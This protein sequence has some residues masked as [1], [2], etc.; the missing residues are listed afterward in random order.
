MG[1][2]AT[3]FDRVSRD[4]LYFDRSH[5]FSGWCLHETFP[6]MAQ[7]RALAI[8]DALRAGPVAKRGASSADVCLLAAQLIETQ[9][10]YEDGNDFWQRAILLFAT[11]RP[12]GDFF[13][14]VDTEDAYHDDPD[15]QTYQ[16]WEPVEED[17]VLRLQK[18]KPRPA[19]P[20]PPKHY[21]IQ[22][23]V[24]RALREALSRA[25]DAGYVVTKG[26]PL[27]VEALDGVFEKA[28]DDGGGYAYVLVDPSETA[29]CE[30]PHPREYP[31]GRH[32][33][34]CGGHKT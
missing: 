24:G 8:D 31:D 1:T 23:D 29:P 11:E 32:C 4:R 7:D 9:R 18:E 12:A 16:R 15:L 34:R 28:K 20:D 27:R 21:A 10:R 22:A 2:D 25:M 6:E 33:W 26:T 5:N 19:E 14:V 3:L 30:C 13:V 17:G